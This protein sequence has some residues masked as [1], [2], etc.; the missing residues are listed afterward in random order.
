MID[1]ASLTQAEWVE[2]PGPGVRFKFR[3]NGTGFYEREGAS[4]ASF[5]RDNLLWKV[6][7]E[8]LYLK[9][10]HAREWTAVGAQLSPGDALPAP[11]FGK[12]ML[13]LAFDPY[14]AVFEERETAPLALVSDTGAALAG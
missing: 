13:V 10:A 14:A 5:R 4:P 3:R 1:A 8:Q 9:F 12:W 6:E 2:H 7:G 11:R